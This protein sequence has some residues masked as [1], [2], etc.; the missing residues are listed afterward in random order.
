MPPD[1]VFPYPGML[2]PSGFTRVT[3][4]DMWVSMAFDGPMAAE[5]RTVGPTGEVLRGV[6]FLGAIGRR[7][8]GASIEQ[9]R[10][11]LASVARELEAE[12]PASNTGWGVD[13]HRRDASRR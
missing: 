1:V 9:V 10:T 3:S 2:G 12:Y 7:R 8:A 4:V 11:D 6:R 13:R 5:Q